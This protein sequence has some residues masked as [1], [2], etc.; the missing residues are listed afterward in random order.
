MAYILT[1]FWLHFVSSTSVFG[2]GT[3][4]TCLSCLFIY[5]CGLSLALTEPCSC[6]TYCGIFCVQIVLCFVGQ[7]SRIEEFKKVHI[8][9]W[10][11]LELS[12]AP[13]AQSS[14]LYWL[15]FSGSF[16]L[17]LCWTIVSGIVVFSCRTT[18]FEGPF[19]QAY[20]LLVYIHHFWWLEC[21]IGWT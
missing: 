2:A 21:D 7:N 19:T 17:I 11:L 18:Y 1:L 20:L 9:C 4:K 6:W 16:W 13:F 12:C 15:N 8:H 5:C 14:G 10:K 3:C